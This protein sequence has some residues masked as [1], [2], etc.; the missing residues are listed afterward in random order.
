MESR[1][2]NRIVYRIIDKETKEPVGS[3]SRAYHDEY[4]FGSADEAEEANCHGIFKDKEKYQIN[5][6]RVVY[7]LLESDIKK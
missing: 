2:L 6:Y 1:Q 7:E 3:Y 4:D 5:K